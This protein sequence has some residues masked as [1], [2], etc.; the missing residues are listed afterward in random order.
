MRRV[1]LRTILVVLI[2]ATTL[3][4]AAF[5]MW[6]VSRS[7]KHQ[8]A[9]IDEQNIKQARAILVAVDQEI[10]STFASLNVLTLLEP[11]DAPDK[12]HFSQIAARV[13]PLHPGW[14]SIR[15]IDSSLQVLASTLGPGSEPPPL[16]PEWVR[17]IVHSARP[18]IS[19]GR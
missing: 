17:E 13:L 1:R 10:Q 12:T 5:A 14:Q 7:S 11:I 19:S 8:A 3:P 4:V 6:V 18:G 2:L 16:D 9:L 15:L